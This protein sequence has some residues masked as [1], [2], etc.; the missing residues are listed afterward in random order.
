MRVCQSSHMA[1]RTHLEVRLPDG[2]VPGVDDLP[3][4][5]STLLSEVDLRGGTGFETGQDGRWWLRVMV[6][7]HDRLSIVEALVEHLEV[8]GYRSLIRNRRG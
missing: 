4:D 2:F 1:S 5:L 6:R 8:L 3:A 7:G